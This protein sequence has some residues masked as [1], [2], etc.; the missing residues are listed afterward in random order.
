MLHEDD[1]DDE[2]SP[3]GAWEDYLDKEHIKDLE[4]FE[5]HAKDHGNHMS[6]MQ[7]LV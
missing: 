1:D 4:G 2:P 3:D 5:K 7:I 6:S